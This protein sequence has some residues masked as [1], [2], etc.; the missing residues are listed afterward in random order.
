[1]VVERLENNRIVITLS[2]NVDIFC[3]QRLIDY[4]KYLEATAGSKAKQSEADK[5]AEEAN[6]NWWNRNKSRFIK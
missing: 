2:S 3:I 5:L 4:G 6:E 1:M